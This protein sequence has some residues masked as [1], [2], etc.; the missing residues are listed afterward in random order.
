MSMKNGPSPFTLTDDK[1]LGVV[2]R[3]VADPIPGGPVWL[4]IWSLA[5]E[6]WEPYPGTIDPAKHVQKL[7]RGAS[8]P[9]DPDYR[10]QIWLVPIE[11]VKR[12]Y[13]MLCS[14]FQ[15]DGSGKPAFAMESWTRA[16]VLVMA[17]MT[18]PC[19]D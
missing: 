4:N 14:V 10:S 7:I 9:S 5:T 19:G 1:Q 13:K 15:L 17:G 18:E 16:H 8:D 11:P 6:S 3:T 12:E 2:Y